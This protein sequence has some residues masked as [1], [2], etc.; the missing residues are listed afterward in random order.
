VLDFATKDAFEGWWGTTSQ[1]KKICKKDIYHKQLFSG[2]F[3]VDKELIFMEEVTYNC[4]E[5]WKDGDDCDC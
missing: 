1:W 2:D 4:T 3:Q 5:S